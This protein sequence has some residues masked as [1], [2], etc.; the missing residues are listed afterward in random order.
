MYGEGFALDAGPEGTDRY[1]VTIALPSPEP[2]ITAY[3]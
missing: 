3:A 1:R 2:V